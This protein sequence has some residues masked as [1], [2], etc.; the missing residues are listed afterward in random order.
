LLNPSPSHSLS[1]GI[2]PP[3]VSSSET[4]SK[5]DAAKIDPRE[6]SGS[7]QEIPTSPE[8]NPVDSLAFGRD[9]FMKLLTLGY[10]SSW[11]G[12]SKD[13]PTHPRVTVLRH[14]ANI[15][16]GDNKESDQAIAVVDSASEPSSVER[17]TFIPRRNESSARFMIGLLVDL[18]NEDTDDEGIGNDVPGQNLERI[19]SR[20]IR[21]MVRT[22]T[23]RLRETVS[24]GSNKGMA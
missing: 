21:I 23:L 19:S 24:G 15:D 20:D 4:L 11:R 16:P 1:P 13:T 9:T 18:E 10:G 6:S 14:A 17:V 12:S 22:L 2:P 3:L 8:G 5:V 7:I